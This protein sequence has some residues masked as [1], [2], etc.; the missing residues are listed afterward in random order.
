MVTILHMGGIV[1]KETP[2]SDRSLTPLSTPFDN[3]VG[4]FLFVV[5]L[6][7]LVLFVLYALFFE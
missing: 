3:F 7:A 5:P 4:N 6:V 2:S 1:M